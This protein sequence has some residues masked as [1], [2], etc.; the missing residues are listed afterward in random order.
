MKAEKPLTK[1]EIT[2]TFRKLTAEKDRSGQY[3]RP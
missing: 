2:K 1:K 3:L